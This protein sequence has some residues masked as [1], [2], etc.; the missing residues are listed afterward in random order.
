[1][2]AAADGSP[3]GTEF[4]NEVVLVGRLAAPADVLVLPS[5]DEVTTWRLVVPRSESEARATGRS[6]SDTLDCAAWSA[7]VRRSAAA[8][9]KD[10]VIEVHG[11]LRRRFWRSPGGVASRYEVS[12]ER[13]RRVQRGRAKRS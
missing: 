10:D 2:T 8:W 9:V 11:A 12:V 4:H 6:A 5:G 3:A 1:M 7:S 13:A